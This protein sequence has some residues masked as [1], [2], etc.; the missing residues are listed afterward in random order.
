MCHQS[1]GLIQAVFEAAGLST[2]SV[3]LCEEITS[4]VGPPRVLQVPF[5]FGFPLGPL[6]ADEQRRDIVEAALALLEVDG[7]RTGPLVEH[8]REDS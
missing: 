7:D 1:V 8:W 6:G 2:V 4:K 3:S 5:P